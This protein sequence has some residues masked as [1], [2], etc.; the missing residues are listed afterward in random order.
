MKE[1]PA[2]NKALHKVALIVSDKEGLPRYNGYGLNVN[3]A[4]KLGIKR[5]SVSKWMNGRQRVPIKH[6]DRLVELS[7]GQVTKEELRQSKKE[8]E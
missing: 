1:H 7:D 8:E 2:L 4:R 6:L 3:L 5:Q